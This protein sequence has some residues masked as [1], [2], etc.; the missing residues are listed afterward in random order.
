MADEYGLD[1]NGL[2]NDAMI[3]EV[4]Q[5]IPKFNLNN[6][7]NKQR[8]MTYRRS[9]GKV[10]NLFKNGPLQKSR[11][12]T[13]DESWSSVG[14]IDLSPIQEALFKN[15]IYGVLTNLD[16]E[17]STIWCFRINKKWA[18][19]DKEGILELNKL[20]KSDLKSRRWNTAINKVY[21]ELED[22]QEEGLRTLCLASFS[23]Q[24]NN[25]PFFGRVAYGLA[26]ANHVIS[27][28]QIPLMVNSNRDQYFTWSFLPKDSTGISSQ[29][30][31]QSKFGK[32]GGERDYDTFVKIRGFLFKDCEPLNQDGSYKEVGKEDSTNNEQS[33]SSSQEE[34]ERENPI[35]QASDALN[36]ESLYYSVSK[37]IMIAESFA[38][39]EYRLI[40]EGSAS[41]D[42]DEE[43][44]Y[45]DSDEKDTDTIYPKGQPYIN[46][47]T[48]EKGIPVLG[49]QY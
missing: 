8:C 16:G 2:K 37:S 44:L 6:P 19:R 9:D 21:N 12:Y 11:V 48:L 35:Q 1:F 43:E 45:D 13:M 25:M 22:K 42:E 24:K 47:L 32:G 14:D 3:D 20:I 46:K 49:P 28:T 30:D 41:G 27:L 17:G 40:N 31:L 23:Y 7:F 38:K 4:F 18:S 10:L 5:G 39:R 34:Q 33:S 29:E 26:Y 15:R 36:N